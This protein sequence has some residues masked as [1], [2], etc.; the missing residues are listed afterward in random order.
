V[1]GAVIRAWNL[2][3]GVLDWN[4]ISVMCDLLGFDDPEILIRGLVIVRDHF[5]R[6][7]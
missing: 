5:N 1:T 4:G 3:G 6:S 7:D 2:L